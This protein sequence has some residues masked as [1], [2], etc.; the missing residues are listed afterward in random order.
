MEGLLPPTQTMKGKKDR[1]GSTEGDVSDKAAA[2]S[3]SKASTVELAI[4]YIKDLQNELSDTRAK[5]ED[6]EKKLAEVKNS[7]SAHCNS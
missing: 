5:L 3:N 1:S 7:S 6:R 2:S 4:A